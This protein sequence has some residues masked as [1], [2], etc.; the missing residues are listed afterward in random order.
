MYDFGTRKILSMK[1]GNAL[2]QCSLTEASNG[3]HALNMSLIAFQS[4][5]SM[6]DY[7]PFLQSSHAKS[8]PIFTYINATPFYFRR[9]SLTNELLDL[10]QQQQQQQQWWWFVMWSRADVRVVLD[11]HSC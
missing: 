7:L 2:S 9:V 10:G 5:S 6:Q 11:G 8:F 3:C 1:Y 4:I